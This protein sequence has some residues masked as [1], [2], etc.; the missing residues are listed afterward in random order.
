MT[1]RSQNDN[2]RRGLG[3]SMSGRAYGGLS[4]VAGFVRA[5]VEAARATDRLAMIARQEV[6]L[7]AHGLVPRTGRRAEMESVRG[8]LTGRAGSQSYPEGEPLPMSAD[9][10]RAIHGFASNV[11]ALDAAARVGEGAIVSQAIDRMRRPI[12][13]ENSDG[14]SRPP[15]MDTTVDSRGR[16]SRMIQQSS[17]GVQTL[18]R[19]R[20]SGRRFGLGGD[21]NSA[22]AS[23]E[24]GVGGTEQGSRL[25]S[26]ELASGELAWGDLAGRANRALGVVGRLSVGSGESSQGSGR[27][28]DRSRTSSNFDRVLTSA[29]KYMSASRARGWSGPRGSMVAP[30][31]LS[32]PEF[33]EPMRG[34][35]GQESRSR[36]AAI[37]INS[38]PTVVINAGEAPGDVE[39][40][41]IGALRAHREELFDQFKRE[42]VR[43]ERSQF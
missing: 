9:T 27:R 16:F 1:K 18:T 29:G 28:F 2:I 4:R 38:T 34:V 11:K 20:N 32:R 39:R 40:Q 33:A 8:A 10:M 31:S 26:G 19:I 23:T 37:T 17:S 36:P 3:E 14:G 6:P 13:R 43:R 41:V 35:Y 25:S 30:A 15:E 5:S 21:P 42:S 12:W 22:K 7:A 24:S